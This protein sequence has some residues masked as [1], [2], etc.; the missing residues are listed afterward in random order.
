MKSIKKPLVLKPQNLSTRTTCKP[1]HKKATSHCQSTT[2]QRK[3]VKNIGTLRFSK[4]KRQLHKTFQIKLLTQNDREKCK[5]QQSIATCPEYQLCSP[6]DRY[7]LVN[8]VS[9]NNLCTNCLSNKHH[10]QSCPSQKRCQVCSGFH[11]TTLRDPA[12]Q[13]KSPTAAFSTEVV[14]G[15]NLTASSSSKASSQNSNK[16]SQKKS[17]ANK[18]PNS[19]YGQIFNNQSEQNWLQI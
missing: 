13:V 11:H 8:L 2:H 9:Q 5:Q 18:A 14:S 7:S 17:Q 12:K 19:R 16:S 6:G 15:S 10:K 4:N 1:S 3:T